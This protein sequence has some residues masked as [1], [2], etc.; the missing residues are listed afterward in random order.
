MFICVNFYFSPLTSHMASYV[1][2]MILNHNTKVANHPSYKEK[3]LKTEDFRSDPTLPGSHF[4]VLEFLTLLTSCRD[5]IW[6]SLSCWAACNCPNTS[7]LAVWSSWNKKTQI[8]WQFCLD[9][10]HTTEW[11]KNVNNPTAS[12]IHIIKLI[13]HFAC[14]TRYSWIFYRMTV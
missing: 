11:L 13:S 12:D 9:P 3:S 14:N 10:V 2:K 8:V 6:V 5:C 1:P 4:Y 7:W